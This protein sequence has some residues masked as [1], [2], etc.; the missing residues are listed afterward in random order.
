MIFAQILA[1]G[2]GTRFGKTKLPK[3]FIKLGTK[4]IIIHTTDQFLLNPQIDHIIISVGKEWINHTENLIKKYYPNETKRISV[5][6]G[7][8][9]RNLTILKGCQFIKDKTKKKSLIITHDAVRPFITQRI[10]DDNIKAGMNTTCV[11]TVIP[12]TDTI[13]HSINGKEI[14]N[15]PIRN[16]YFLG[17]T[18]QTFQVDD[19][20]TLYNSLSKDEKETLTD[21]CKIFIIKNKKVELVQGDIYNLKITHLEDLEIAKA[22][23]IKDSND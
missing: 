14:N 6:E 20:I 10:I 9:T 13:V 8:E 18:P 3:Q 23:L 22:I 4:P 11:D 16:Q 7:G 17:Q 12:A 5:V 15:I 21:A 2:K 19:F 1:G